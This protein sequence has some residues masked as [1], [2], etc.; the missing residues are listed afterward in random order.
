[1][2]HQHMTDDQV[3]R[4]PL[5]G[6]RAV[7]L[8]EIMATPTLI[9]A[10]T[11]KTTHRARRVVG[12]IG[13]AAA[14]AA[15]ITATFVVT[16]DTRT[17]PEQQALYPAAAVAAAENNP[18]L[19]LDMAG[20]KIT[21]V[22][23]FA[24][25]NG[26][27]TYTNGPLSIEL[28]WYDASEYPSFYEE[29]TT[30]SVEPVQPIDVAGSTGILVTFRAGEDFEA[31]LPPTGDSFIGLRAQAK[32]NGAAQFKDVLSH[33]HAVSVDQWLARMPASVVSPVN[34]EAAVEAGLKDVPLAPGTTIDHY[35]R[36]LGVNQQ[37]SFNNRLAGEVACAWIAAWTSAHA[38]G[39]DSAEKAA[40]IALEGSAS[41][42]VVKD[43]GPEY[44]TG[45]VDWVLRDLRAGRV[46]SKDSD[47][48][49]CVYSTY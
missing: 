12:A 9:P 48:F 1:M 7:L 16:N 19:A 23:G 10:A 22:A 26:Y 15:V 35:T 17:T 21:E 44:F 14:V 43:M 49:G 42:P 24:N 34:A 8:E 41:W 45:S 38:S 40:V 27:V 28:T 2:N 13:A 47:L 36:L 37:D 33:V 32:W 5:A 20:W 31:V 11:P 39:D 18:R 4:L 46:P 29:R 3:A 6:A 25:N 30:E